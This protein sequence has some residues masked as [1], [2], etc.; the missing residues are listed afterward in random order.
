MIFKNFA[1]FTDC[2]RKI[3]NTQIGNPNDLDV[4]ML[5]YNLIEYNNYYLKTLESLWQCYRDDLNDNMT[6]SESFK[7]NTKITG[8]TPAAGFQSSNAFKTLKYFVLKTLKMTLIN[9]EI[10]LI[11]TWSADCVISS[12]TGATK[13]KITDRKLYAAFV[14]LL[15]IQNCSNN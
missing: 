1:S 15:L 11:F 5:R 8:K 6:E 14:T 10:N 2:V 12:A 7:Y 13:F 3:N 9:C 4:V